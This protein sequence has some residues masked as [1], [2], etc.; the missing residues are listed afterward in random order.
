[1][2]IK[3]RAEALLKMMV[4][5]VVYTVVHIKTG[6]TGCKPR[7]FSFYD[8]DY[9]G[10]FGLFFPDAAID[11][12]RCQPQNFRLFASRPNPVNMP[13]SFPDVRTRRFSGTVR[14]ACA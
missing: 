10:C 4:A 6:K 5:A 2:Q 3:S 12:D 13:M 14:L 8:S 9:S 7:P 11:F 1:M